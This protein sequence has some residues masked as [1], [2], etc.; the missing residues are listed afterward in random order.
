MIDIQITGTELAFLLDV[1]KGRNNGKS[2]EQSRQMSPDWTDLEA[3]Y[4]GV[5]GEHVL[6]RVYGIPFDCASYGSAGDRGVDI[7]T[8]TPGAIKTNHRVGG[9]LILERWGDISRVEVMH[10]VDGPCRPP[11]VCVCSDI[12]PTEPQTWRYVGWITVADFTAN[13]KFANWGLGPRRYC[14][15][16]YLTQSLLRVERQTLAPVQALGPG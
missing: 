11:H 6:S 14:E 16:R 10:L 5:K 4:V 15:Q 2:P 8:P 12:A 3:D 7:C 13:S 9:Y 1:A